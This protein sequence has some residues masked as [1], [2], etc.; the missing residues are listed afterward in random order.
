MEKLN[1]ENFYKKYI[2]CITSKDRE[3][4]VRKWKMLS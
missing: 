4:V 1:A 3:E 2:E